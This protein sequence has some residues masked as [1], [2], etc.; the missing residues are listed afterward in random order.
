MSEFLVTPASFH[1][2]FWEAPSGIPTPREKDIPMEG[3]VCPKP[4]SALLSQVAP[5]ET[6]CPPSGLPSD[7]SSPSWV[8]PFLLSSMAMLEDFR[9]GLGRRTLHLGSRQ[10][11]FYRCLPGLTGLIGRDQDTRPGSGLTLQEASR[12]IFDGCRYLKGPGCGPLR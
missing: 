7:L 10:R 6:S 9:E 8:L 1:S 4:F 12:C 5:S 11:T 3:G 2:S